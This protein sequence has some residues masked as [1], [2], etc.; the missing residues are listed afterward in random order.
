MDYNQEAALAIIYKGGIK[1]AEFSRSSTEDSVGVS[2]LRLSDT[3]DNS[4]KLI[5]PVHG[6][7]A[8]TAQK[9]CITRA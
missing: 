5:L 1:I 6:L 9:S 8:T 4:F 2:D 3:T 7:K